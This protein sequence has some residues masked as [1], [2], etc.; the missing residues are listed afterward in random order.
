MTNTPRKNVNSADSVSIE[1]AFKILY[2]A[3]K[4]KAAAAMLNRAI[5]DGKAH[6][7]ANNK[8]IH[9]EFDFERHLRIVAK[10]KRGHWTA[11]MEMRAAV[12]N[13]D[14]ITWT[15]SRPEV[16]ALREKW[17][18]QKHPGG[19][20]RVYDRDDILAAAFIA[21]SKKEF[22]KK[23]VVSDA[24]FKTYS[25]NDLAADVRGILGEEKCPKET[26][27]GEILDPLLKHLQLL[28]KAGR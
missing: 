17:E 26:Q 16:T 11:E 23:G 20:P 24:I 10:K 12:K 14:T 25:G 6:V 28:L 1:E 13:F 27:L 3:M 5:A 15:M 4:P 2:P 7:R 22:F 21:L 9:D 8:A 19:A 18:S